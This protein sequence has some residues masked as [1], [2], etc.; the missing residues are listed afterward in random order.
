M[1]W[2]CLLLL[3][4]AY[5]AHNLSYFLSKIVISYQIIIIKIKIKRLRNLL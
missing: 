4:V 2:C 1:Y 5:V 3:F